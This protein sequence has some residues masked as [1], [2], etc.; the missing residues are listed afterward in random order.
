MAAESIGT[1]K[2]ILFGSILLLLVVITSLLCLEFAMRMIAPERYLGAR[3]LT[4]VDDA[5]KI[6]A[7]PVNTVQYFRHPDAGARTTLLRNNLGIR[8]PYDVTPETLKDTLNIGIFG[9]SFVE[10]VRLDA[11]YMFSEVL[12]SLLNAST[13]SYKVLNF[14]VGA[15]SLDQSYLRYRELPTEIRRGIRDVVVVVSFR[16]LA[17]PNKN[18]I[19]TLD[20]SGHLLLTPRGPRVPTIAKWVRE[21]YTT[22]LFIDAYN[23]LSAMLTGKTKEKA[24]S[25]LED[26]PAVDE[27]LDAKSIELFNAIL[28]SWQE[29][30]KAL[31][32]RLVVAVIPLDDHEAVVR[33][34]DARLDVV[35]L[36]R[37]FAEIVPDAKAGI[38]SFHNDPHWN[39]AGNLVAGVAFYK[40]LSGALGMPD[41]DTGAV[42]RILLS[43][44]ARHPEGWQPTPIG[45]LAI[46][47]QQ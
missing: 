30:V 21:F 23:S 12:Q 13:V 15:Y 26:S 38:L 17:N 3:T 22:Y 1:G 4:S 8:A 35:D 19:A 39:E 11:P 34:S 44:Y 29:D 20:A 43:H 32:G 14:G 27:P 31:G 41:L 2:R 42:T 46:S 40:G 25:K 45:N 5:T 18:D 16:D 37:F 36:H 7:P 33:K 9:A 6:W 28:L 24:K 10:N 47:T